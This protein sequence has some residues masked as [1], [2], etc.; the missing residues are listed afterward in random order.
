MVDHATASKE[1]IEKLAAAYKA[2]KEGTGE[3]VKAE[4]KKRKDAPK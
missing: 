3:T 1:C 4:S 2:H